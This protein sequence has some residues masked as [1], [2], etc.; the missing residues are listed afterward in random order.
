MVKA[1]IF[2]GDDFVSVFFF[3]DKFD[4]NFAGDSFISV[5][6]VVTAFGI[7]NYEILTFLIRE[8]YQRR[9]QRQRER[10]KSYNSFTKRNNNFAHA[11]RV[12][13]HYCI[14]F[15]GTERLQRQNA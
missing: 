14:F 9:H 5:P 15:A 12:F 1:M 11:S 8:L 7:R 4:S 2:I 10:Q 3:A 13:A 6:E